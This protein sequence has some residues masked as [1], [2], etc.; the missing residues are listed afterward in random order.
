MKVMPGF[1]GARHFVY[2]ALALSVALAG[3]SKGTGTDST[4]AVQG[5]VSIAYV[6]R[7]NTIFL[8]S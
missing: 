5:D 6:K 7:A 2:A 4:V 1:N 3:C 8:P